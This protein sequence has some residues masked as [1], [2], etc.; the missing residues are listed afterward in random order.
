MPHACLHAYTITCPA[1]LN[2]RR[3]SHL[4]TF[5]ASGATISSAR[6]HHSSGCHL[7]QTQW[8]LGLQTPDNLTRLNKFQ[9]AAFA[10]QR[11]VEDGTHLAREQETQLENNRTPTGSYANIPDIN[12]L[13][14]RQFRRQCVRPFART[15]PSH[16][17]H[18]FACQSPFVNSGGCDPDVSALVTD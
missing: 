2:P 5:S 15:I 9:S 1:N 11:A 7:R 4:Q 13:V 16:T 3:F 14:K 18:A 17:H 10:D 12:S 6:A 8:L